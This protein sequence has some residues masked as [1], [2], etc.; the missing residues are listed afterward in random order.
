MQ[1]V[2]FLADRSAAKATAP[3]EQTAWPSLVRQIV[4]LA[5]LGL[6]VTVLT[7]EVVRYLRL[8]AYLDHI[9]GSIVGVGWLYAQGAPLYSLRD[10]FEQFTN[11]WGPLAYLTVVPALKLIGPN[12]LASKL[13]AA[14]ALATTIG[15]T[16][17]RF[18]RSPPMQAV[19]GLFLLVAGLAA[20]SPMSFWIRADPFETLLV[21]VALTTAASPLCVGLCIGLAVNFKIHAFLYFLPILIELWS[22]R[23]WRAA[24]PLI[25]CAAAV[26]LAPFLAPGISLHDYLATLV[27]QIGGRA[28]TDEVLA[29]VL[30]YGAALALPVLLP[31][32]RRQIPPP[33]RLYGWA[34]LASLVLVVYPA[35]LPGAGPY[36]FLPLLPVLAEARRRLKVDGIG[37]E[38]A[39]FPLLFFAAITTQRCLTEMHERTSWHAY[40]SEALSLARQQPAGTVDVGYGDNQRS[41]EIAQLAKAELALHGYP[42][43]IDAQILMELRETSVDGS[44]RWVPYLT[45]CQVGRWLTPRGEEPFAVRSYFYDDGLLFDD[46]FRAAFAANYRPVAA[47]AH[48]TVWGCSHD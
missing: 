35:S 15:L 30:A 33:Q 9:E 8:D 45:E 14:I 10:G 41:Y 7:M 46:A 4:V 20:L 40:A 32:C 47:S 36:H 48:F 24:P 19:Q 43:W 13:L 2:P 42:R 28:H 6:T 34:A 23:G 37:A 38:L 39:V 31:L 27:Q 29:P 5:G 22:R 18:R 44:Q 11:I 12:I 21:A 16:A 17:I 1:S 25:A 3:L 26:F